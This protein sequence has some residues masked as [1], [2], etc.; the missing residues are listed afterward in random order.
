MTRLS[1][2]V[3]ILAFAITFAAPLEA[4]QSEVR[5]IVDSIRVASDLPALG[6]AII[7]PDSTVALE[8]VGVRRIGDTT[9]ATVNDRFHLGSD[10][11]AMTAG[12]LGLLV[13]QGKLRWTSPI[14][15]L[16]PE[17]ASEMRPEYRTITVR[18]LLSHQSGLVPNPTIQ[19]HDGSPRRQ[20]EA[21][22]KWVLSQPPATTRNTY[23]YANSNYIV[24]GAIAERLMNGEY[25]TLVVDRLLRPMGITTTGFGAPGSS[26]MVDQPWPHLV[27]AVGKRTAVAP[28]PESDNPPVFGP[29]GRAN[30][31][32]GDWARWARVV[33]R[34]AGGGASPWSDST[35]RALVTPAV[36]VD[37]S[38]G[39]AL[40][41][42]VATRPWA[43][44]GG[45]VLTHS[46][47]N[48]MNFAVLWLAPEGKFGVLVVTN[49]GGPAAARATDAVVGRLIA[50]RR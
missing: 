22:V 12:L 6:A 37:A 28:G 48:T 30:M 35:A 11:K 31:T 32:L 17:L 34:A 45:R 9:R 2:Q 13:D 16:F 24:A 33:L 43:G 39:Y 40:G 10:T 14:A 27:D 18:E 41:W 4:Q 47:S 38:T 23:A 25:E 3:T 15:T 46:G 8:V 42:L 7:T 19:F 36:S 50:L 26:T 44:P 49:Q 21:F 1:S 20:R 5:R 29:A